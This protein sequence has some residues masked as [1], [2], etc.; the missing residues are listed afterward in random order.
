[1]NPTLVYPF[2]LFSLTL[3]VGAV[4]PYEHYVRHSQDFQPVKQERNWALKAWPAWTYMPWTYQWTIGY[5]EA[6]ARWSLDHGYNGAFIPDSEV[7]R[8]IVWR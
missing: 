5:D 6:A 4:D 1:M 3:T 8:G 2:A 7:K